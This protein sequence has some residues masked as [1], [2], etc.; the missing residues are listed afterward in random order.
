MTAPTPPHHSHDRHND[1]ATIAARLAAGQILPGDDHAGDD[2]DVL[3]ARRYTHPGLGD[4]PVVRL[5]PQTLGQAE[6]L[7]C[8]FLGFEAP[9]STTEVG[10]SKRS[11]LG[12]PA[13]ALVN[14]P[15][16]GHHALN[17]VKDIERLARTA[18]SKAGNAK[19]GFTN[20]GKML[21]R[22]APH[23]L[24]T[25]Y[26]QAG[27]IFLTH[28][29]DTYA[30]SMFGKAREAEDVHNLDIDP[31]RT[32][33][34]FLEFAFAGALTAKALS[35]YSKQLIKRGDADAGYELF[36]TLCVERTRGGLP[37]YTGMPE[38][39]RRLAKAAKRDL[40]AEDERLLRGV[41]DSPSITQASLAFW[42]SY[43]SSLITLARRDESIRRQLLAVF[44]ATAGVH[45][46]I[47]LWL[48]ILTESGASTL[49]T[50]PRSADETDIGLPARWLSA[51]LA[52]RDKRARSPRSQA[53]LQLVETMVE[54][55]TADDVPVELPPWLRGELDLQDLLVAS[56]VP[57][58]ESHQSARQLWV[59]EWLRDTQPG[60][61]DLAALGKSA[62]YTMALGE[63]IVAHARHNTDAGTISA[64]ATREVLAVPGL[65]QALRNWI[66]FRV[67]A[68]EPTSLPDLRDQLNA[69][70]V[71]RSP[72][73]FSDV[74]EAATILSA[75]D[76][77]AALHDSLRSGV[78]DEMAWPALEAAVERLSGPNW[79]S[80]D[81][82][83]ICG[84]GWPA[85]VLRRGEMFLVVGPEGILFEHLSRIPKEARRHWRFHPSAAWFDGVLL[86][87]WQ[88]DDAE[89]AYWS[90]APETVFEVAKNTS[91]SRYDIP[92]PSIA[93]SDGSRFSGDRAVRPGDTSI[94]RFWDARSDGSALWSGRLSRSQRWFEV[95]AA[96]GERG[97]SSVPA[98]IEDFAAE[99]TALSYAYCDLRPSVPET[100]NSPLG[101]AGGLHGWRVRKET[102]GSWLGEGIDGR[103]VR[104]A[105]RHNAPVAQL[106]LP[107]GGAL[108]V[109][110]A[111]PPRLVGLHNAH[112]S[113]VGQ[114]SVGSNHPH[115]APGTA[116][117]P[118]LD[119]WHLLVPRDEAGSLA[120]RTLDR[121]V[122]DE[123]LRRVR[124][125]LDRHDEELA[126]LAQ[127]ADE[128]GVVQ[129]G[130]AAAEAGRRLST[131]ITDLVTSALPAITHPGLVAGISTSVRQ[132]ADLSRSYLAF[133]S[134]AK[135]ARDFDATLEAS[136]ADD[137]MMSAADIQTALDW[138]RHSSD[139]HRRGNRN[140]PTVLPKFLA[141]LDA[142]AAESAPR[143]KSLIAP[144]I[145]NWVRWLPHLETLVYRA[146]SEFTPPYQ[147]DA[148]VFLLRTLA[149]SSITDGSGRWRIVTVTAPEGADESEL[150]V[151][152]TPEGF[153]VTLERNRTYHRSTQRYQLTS[154]QYARTP[155]S[156]ALAEGWQLESVTPWGTPPDG[157]RLRH[158]LDLIIERGPASWRPEAVQQLVERT[159]MGIAE[160]AILLA[161]MPSINSW[162]ANYLDTDLRKQ[163]GVSAAQAKSVRE[164]FRYLNDTLRRELLGA[165]VPAD[166]AEL[167]TVGPAVD[168]IAAVWGAK[169]G[170]RHPV[171]EDVLVEAA[172]R[173]SLR[174]TGEWISGVTNPATTPWLAAEAEQ[175]DAQNGRSSFTPST[176][177]ALATVLPWL[178]YRLPVGSPLRSQLSASL[179]AARERVSRPEF[180]LV[181]YW[182]ELERLA[183]LLGDEVTPT[184]TNTQGDATAEPRPWMTLAFN[185]SRHCRIAVRPGLVEPADRELFAAILEGFVG[186][187]HVHQLNILHDERL[188]AACAGSH[189][190]DTDPAAY[191]QD[192]NVSV[193][194]LVTEVATRFGLP[195][196]AAALYL[197]LLALPDP[198][199]A[200]TAKWTGWKPARLRKARAALAET[201]LVVTAKRARAGR[202]L[203]LPGGWLDF[204]SPRLPLETWK[205]ALYDTTGTVVPE[206]PVADLF[207]RAW[208][209]VLDGDAPAYEELQ[210]G[211]R[212]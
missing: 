154:L 6:D 98:F 52:T 94:P 126:R 24:P 207:A 12:F 159:G 14:D 167:W 148:L 76:V 3:T 143:S 43:R 48:E 90:D 28:G 61:R 69:L 145:M 112:G 74:P 110:A 32:R 158:M 7:T 10:T 208:Q 192:P 205:S 199:D 196:D 212:R 40:A 144:G 23:F 44:P 123:L 41:L 68:I 197:Q 183:P 59:E 66:T 80:N 2:R 33:E 54:R 22:T 91:Y 31:E 101:E 146:A 175:S 129:D 26:E 55:L 193:P 64:A 42:R 92:V 141:T 133:T 195:E 111:N 114:V 116:L 173:L 121:A 86:V 60:R 163:L 165:A 151:V 119:W 49:L 4:R 174:D 53:L 115:T 187:I 37:P 83:E 135:Q 58:S 124:D 8:E 20:L 134:I 16:N 211:K 198:T 72:G 172:K 13:W 179:A 188:E 209:R 51:L 47:E 122:V 157:T 132:A 79:S 118:P 1:P 113:S 189:T 85:L 127:A 65:R 19:D 77:G 97:R 171:P 9:V 36:H 149:D 15:A 106:Q 108:T 99:D 177:Q 139:H 169:F 21:G 204:K 82:L 107:H 147:R 5:V 190:E 140:Q 89:L 156:F 168:A 104:L 137:A 96:T 120:L 185:G 73:A 155:G 63:G 35:A 161:G 180:S 93:L 78:F 71:L 103:R 150:R 153:L 62:P 67:T 152:P 210:T 191:A 117:V 182:V 11:A 176:L 201:D 125:E 25:F 178:A 27:R 34:V 30:A 81:E 202:S 56:R 39:L 45:E 170:I 206:E 138:F 17:L 130:T 200:D 128:A 87:R 109:T 46:V 181:G 57:L 142:T 18:R 194:Q 38:D 186:R 160:A 70:Q 50:E 84:E 29:N 102:D 136:S 100:L 162:E 88:T 184:G 95:D 131:L 166:P 203:F 105:G 75:V 164:R